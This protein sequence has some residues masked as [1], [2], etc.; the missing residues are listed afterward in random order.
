[1]KR[2]ILPTVWLL[3]V[4]TM[5]W[6]G[7]VVDT[8]HTGSVRDLATTPNG[9]LL[10][11]VSDDGK[12]KVWDRERRDAVASRQISTLPLVRLALHPSLKRVAVVE[13]NGTNRVFL[14]VWNWETGEN[15]FRS[16][17]DEPPLVLQFSPQGSYIVTTKPTFD[18]VSIWDAD[19]GRRQY[20]LDEGFGIVTYAVVSNSETNI[21]T[22]TGSNGRIRYFDLASGRQVQEVD[23]RAGLEHLTLLPNRRYA[24]GAGGDGLLVVDIVDGDVED[25]YTLA[26][27]SGIE[28]EPGGDQ[29]VVKRRHTTRGDTGSDDEN[30]AELEED[31]ELLRFTADGGSIR[32]QFNRA[33]SIGTEASAYTAYSRRMYYGTKNG[34]I[35]YYR[36]GSRFRNVF[37]RNVIEPVSDISV[38]FQSLVLAGRERMFR[39][40]SD[41]LSR[42]RE[43]PR[44]VRSRTADKPTEEPVLLEA[45]GSRNVLLW[46]RDRPTGTV[47][48]YDPIFGESEV[49]FEE[50]TPV[51]HVHAYDDGYLILSGAGSFRDL[52]AD[53]LETRFSY[54]SLGMEKVFRSEEYGI[55]VAK[56]KTD[57]FSSALLRIDP[58]TGETVPIRTS[59]RLIFDMA[60]DG[61]DELFTLGLRGRGDDTETVLRRRFGR[62]LRAANTILTAPGDNLNGQVIFH[63]RSDTAFAVINEAQPFRIRDNE[64]MPVD[65]SEHRVRRI[66]AIGNVLA[67][68]NQDGSVSFWEA[69]TGTYLADLFLIRGGQW[70]L[71]TADERFAAPSRFD[72][73]VLRYVPDSP[74]DRRSLE[75]RRIELP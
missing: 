62:S 57:D 63:N 28:R 67:A 11:S 24:L 37:A 29:I 72:S 75:Q 10:L 25:S 55:L 58:D 17:L 42:P 61:R 8:A 53:S 19:T 51:R 68:A 47:W 18:S 49:L 23:T 32:R 39:F 48:N 12:L 41:I 54:T 15:V 52:D 3:L 21:M 65:R 14:S 1:M 26:G 36:A 59:E 74:R 73:S 27:I 35:Y 40:S 44:Y 6:G 66:Q 16:A 9:E 22:Y 5:A 43:V 7:I 46:Q 56:S 70:V 64:P 71:V 4:S 30:G 50:E 34:E 13:S 2:C 31:V 20:F 38:G 60:Y 33:T 69:D 45:T